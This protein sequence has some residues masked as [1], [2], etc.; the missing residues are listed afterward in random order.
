[1]EA[2][3]RTTCTGISPR[4]HYIFDVNTEHK[5]WKH[6]DLTRLMLMCLPAQSQ[7]SKSLAGARLN[8]T[9]HLR[10]FKQL[11]GDTFKLQSM[12]LREPDRTDSE[13]SLGALSVYFFAQSPLIDRRSQQALRPD[14]GALFYLSWLNA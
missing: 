2:D 10:L 7:W 9:V 8:Y 4:V 5:Y 1:M 6:I 13:A 11:K 3:V 12:D 14:G